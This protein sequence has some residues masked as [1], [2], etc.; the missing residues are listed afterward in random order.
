M[1]GNW[2]QIFEWVLATEG[3]YVNHPNDPGGPTNMGVTQRT[4][5]AWTGLHKS[6]KRITKAE[7]RDIFE[8][9]YFQKVMGDDLPS[10]LDYAVVDYAINSGPSRAVKALQR[11]LGVTA[12]GIMGAQTLRAVTTSD[13]PVA[14][15]IVTYCTDRLNWMQRLKT[16]KHFGKGWSA[17]VMGRVMGAQADDI[18]VIDR[19]IR[20]ARGAKDI[21]APVAVAPAKAVGE[22]KLTATLS[23]AL[24]SPQALGTAGSVVGSVAAMA[25][26]S[27]PVQYA[28]AAVL[29]LAAVA[30][31]IWMMKR[32]EE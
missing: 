9:Q 18:G 17:R 5:D 23:D 13:I 30:G 4:Y 15:M 28:L 3:G 10:G 25:S 1:K 19:S 6:V 12:D 21:P 2:N 8:A 32:K 31:I 20:L 11:Q 7:V 26:G 24:T 14:E 29:V 22:E 16:W 27:G